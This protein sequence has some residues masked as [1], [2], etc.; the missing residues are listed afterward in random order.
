MP[1]TI[2]VELQGL[3]EA[4]SSLQGLKRSVRNRILKKAITKAVQPITKDAKARAPRRSGALRKSIYYKVVSY[5][6]NGTVAGVIGPRKGFARV[7][8]GKRIDPVYYAHLVE[9]GRKGVSVKKV[10]VLSDGTRFYGSTVAAVAPQRFLQ[11]AW[12]AGSQR[13]AATFAAIVAE[14]IRKE[15]AKARTKS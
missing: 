2:R 4:I 10:K 15:A 11:Q 5:R 8:D 14:E 1:F 6:R 3:Q 7:L 12:A 13:A 9:L